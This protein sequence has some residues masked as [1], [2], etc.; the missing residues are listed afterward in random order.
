MK[1]AIIY[2]LLAAGCWWISSCKKETSI[3]NGNVAAGN[4]TA[5]IN[6]V[7]WSAASSQEQA[8]II[9]GL[10]NITG[11]SVD[12]Q[13]ISISITDTVPGTYVLSAQTPSIAVYGSADSSD[14]YAYST[15][16]SPDTTKAGGTVTISMIDT[17]NK[18]VTGTFAFKVYRTFDGH[19]KTITSGVFEQIPYTTSL[20]AGSHD[21][22][23][24]AAI[25]GGDWDAESIQASALDGTLSLVGASANGS[26]SVALIFPDYASPGTYALTSSSAIPSYVAV[27][28][29]VS[30]GA[31]TASPGTSGSI[32]ILTNN[33]STMRMTGTFQFS[34]DDPNVAASQ[35]SIT[36]GYFSVYYGQ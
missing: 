36:N 14:L 9:R 8:T 18:T 5:V 19:G 28:D 35:H 6:G 2:T 3:E 26:Q 31:N 30:N 33:T 25:D 17:V 10:I 27:Y 1:K 13:E 11:V 20:P 22:T 16:Q 32:T 7:P 23:V 24:T 21:D 34:T 12:N 29:E 15:S 4:F